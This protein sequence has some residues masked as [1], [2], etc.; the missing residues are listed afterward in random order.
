[1][2]RS[3]PGSPDL[4]NK[5][6][7][8]SIVRA[9]RCAAWFPISTVEFPN[10]RSCHVL[11]ERKGPMRVHPRHH[12]RH[13]GTNLFSQDWPGGARRRGLLYLHIEVDGCCNDAAEC[14]GT[15]TRT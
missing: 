4:A 6:R 12:P 11:D 3:H 7:C 8:F 9:L 1:M 14:A 13:P 10:P 2:V 15:A 5:I